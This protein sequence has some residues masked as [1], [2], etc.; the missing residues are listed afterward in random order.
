MSSFKTKKIKKSKNSFQNT[1]E[2]EIQ[3]EYLHKNTEEI[4][5]QLPQKSEK[6]RRKKS[7]TRF[8]ASILLI[9]SSLLFVAVAGAKYLGNI[10]VGGNLQESAIFKK[11]T[12]QN[13]DPESHIKKQTQ[14]IL[15][16]GIGGK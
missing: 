1:Q 14:N 7:P 13:P 15:I 12:Q 4:H 9:L 6:I 5:P 2:H 3:R 11:L 16:A 8:I 10:Q